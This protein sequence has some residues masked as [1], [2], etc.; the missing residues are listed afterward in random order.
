MRARHRKNRYMNIVDAIPGKKY[1]ICSINAGGKLNS[2]L[3]SMG[4]LPH[5]TFKVTDKPYGG[6]MTIYIKGSRIALGKGLANKI[7]IREI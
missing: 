7:I 6:P 4:I 2:R 3:C 5:E 1:R